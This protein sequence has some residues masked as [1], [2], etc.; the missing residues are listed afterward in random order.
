MVFEEAA[1]ITKFK[2]QKKEAL[3]KL[4]YTEQNLLR[5]EDTIREV[6]RQIG[7][8]QRQ[9]GKARRYQKIMDELR[10]WK[11]SLP[12]MNSTPSMSSCRKFARNPNTSA[13]TLRIIPLESSKRKPP[14][15]SCVKLSQNWIVRLAHPTARVGVEIEVEHHENRIQ[16]NEQRM[17]N[18]TPNMLTRKPILP[19]QE[20]RKQVDAE[21]EGIN[22]QLADSGHALDRARQHVTEKR[23]IVETAE[24]EINQ[25]QTELHDTNN[26]ATQLTQRLTSSRNEL[27]ALELQK[28]GNAARLEKLSAE[29]IQLEEERGK[30]ETSLGNSSA[31]WR[32][33]RCMWKPT[34]AQLRNGKRACP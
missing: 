18:S 7:S 10:S 31:V 1:G 6:K 33:T 4:D 20:R 30:L 17:G 12:A 24:S 26:E 9:A 19:G 5:L 11:P 23:G 27:N 29:K 2:Q 34:A 3:R 15:R 32:T 16:Y 8:L 22:Q 14:S 28:Q 21:L 13:T 25:R